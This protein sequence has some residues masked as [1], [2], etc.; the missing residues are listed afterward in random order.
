[1]SPGISAHSSMLIGLILAHSADLLLE[2]T[3]T[4][5]QLSS[6]I[7]Y[8]FIYLSLSCLPKN[9]IFAKDGRIIGGGEAVSC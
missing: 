4:K 8:D 7:V 2:L 3:A 6:E 9:Y 5:L 1:M